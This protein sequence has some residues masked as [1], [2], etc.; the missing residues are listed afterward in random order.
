VSI[1]QHMKDLSELNSWLSNAS[2]ID[3]QSHNPY[4]L[5][6][7]VSVGVFS[8]CGQSYPGASNYHDAPNALK[9]VLVRELKK[10]ARECFKRA[11]AEYRQ[12]LI[13]QIED[14]KAEYEATLA[15]ALSDAAEVKP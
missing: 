8:Y 2:N 4:A 11:V 5:R 9:M 13:K 15:K 12:G 1:E 6:I 3:S 14:K 7:D 10:V